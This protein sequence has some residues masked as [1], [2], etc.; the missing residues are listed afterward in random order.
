MIVSGFRA[1]VR[2]QA[3]M[4]AHSPLPGIGVLGIPFQPMCVHRLAG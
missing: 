4:N 1:G 3:R 2:N